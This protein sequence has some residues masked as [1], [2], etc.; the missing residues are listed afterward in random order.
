[1]E[2]SSES[3]MLKSNKV[4]FESYILYFTVLVIEVSSIVSIINIINESV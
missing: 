1:M 2:I 4:P 3:H